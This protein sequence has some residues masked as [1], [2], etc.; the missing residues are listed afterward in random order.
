MVGGAAVLGY[1]YIYLSIY[2]FVCLAVYCIEYNAY[3]SHSHSCVDGL[4]GWLLAVLGVE[5][6]SFHQSRRFKPSANINAN[7]RRGKFNGKV[8]N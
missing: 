2:L 7:D 8:F 5:R 6:G 3:N 4:C 1:T